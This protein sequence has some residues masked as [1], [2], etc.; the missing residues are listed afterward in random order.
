MIR[1]I[2]D[3]DLYKFTMQQAVLKL[4]PDAIATYEFTSR[5]DTPVNE[6]F[7][8]LLNDKI[9][10]MAS[11]VM[12]NTGIMND[13]KIACPFLKPDYL[14]Y[15]SEY[16]FDPN[17]IKITT[18]SG[19]DFPDLKNN[20]TLKI[21]GPWHQTILWEVPLLALIS[22]CYYETVDTNWG[23][24]GQREKLE[25]KGKQLELAGVVF[26]DF[27]TRRRRCFQ[28]QDLAVSVLKNYRGF[29]GTS[30]V[31]LA[32]LNKVKPIG[33]MAHE[34]IMG[35]SALE[36]L[37]HANRFALRAW[38]DVYQGE[39]GI[40]LTDTFGSEA[41]FEDFDSVLAR[42]Y[43]GVRHDSGSGFEF[44]DKMIEHYKSLGIGP[45]SKTIMFSDGLDVPLAI[46]LKHYCDTKGIGSGCGIGTNFTNDYY[47][48]P[49]LNI[50]IKL[51]SIRKN[52]NSKEIQVVKLSDVVSKATGDADELRIAKNVF[53]GDKLD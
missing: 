31:L 20:F 43:D 40:A 18:P 28:T 29:A 37:R 47:N 12:D 42:A 17:Q 3:T 15:L 32:L 53:F 14:S 13:L 35:V 25:H 22:E 10:D 4:Y 33:T 16:R 30:N 7:L 41:F 36:S 48:S 8:N 39:L 23:Q 2:L 11:L 49:A 21:D 52:A 38:N 50:V 5:R 26:S 45:M 6:K 24:R 51:R 9:G 27:G 46:Q 1:S 19:R 44:T 34:F